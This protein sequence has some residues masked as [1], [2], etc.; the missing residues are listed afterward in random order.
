M[1]K[2]DIKVIT[3]LRENGRMPLTELSRR[4]GLPIST[5][6]EK[7][8]KR[9]A[10]GAVRPCVLLQFQKLGFDTRAFILLGVEPA[11]K[12]K[13]L[14]YLS[15]HANVNSLFRI[16]SGWTALIEGVFRD[17]YALETFIETVEQL[18]TIRQKQV[19]YVLDE[20]R[21]EAFFSDAVLAEG[22][23]ANGTKSRES[24]KNNKKK[25]R[26]TNTSEFHPD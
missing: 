21:R 24:L 14:A 3:N 16:N 11:E 12:E 17:M 18:F 20:L 22:L 9:I 19:C 13:L 15:K 5:I 6:H 4:I 7:L 25:Q 1:K 23:V 2:N 10:Q 8:K 26:F